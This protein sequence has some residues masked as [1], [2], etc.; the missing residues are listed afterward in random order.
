MTYSWRRLQLDRPLQ[1]HRQKNKKRVWRSLRYKG[2][3]A[4]LHD[5]GQ[6]TQYHHWMRQLLYI[7]IMW[8]NH[9]TSSL[10]ETITIHHQYVRQSL[11]INTNGAYH[12]IPSPYI[13]TIRD[14]HCTSSLYEAYQSNTVENWKYLKWWH[15]PHVLSLL[16]FLQCML[17]W[18]TE[19]FT[20][21]TDIP[22]RTEKYSYKGR[23]SRCW[24]RLCWRPW[25]GGRRKIDGPRHWVDFSRY[26]F[27]VY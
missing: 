23:W 25:S 6:I 3:I 8:D 5:I 14:N 2:M 13:S 4:Y 12:C 21:L 15:L 10:C 22:S 11:Y 1:A 16:L 18:V 27:L 24:R 20:L 26:V 17:W 9:Y 19:K 7:T